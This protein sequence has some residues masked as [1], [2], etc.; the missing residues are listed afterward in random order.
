MLARDQRHN[1]TGP[2]RHGKEEDGAARLG[3][4]AGGV[5]DAVLIAANLNTASGGKRG[6]PLNKTHRLPEGPPPLNSILE[7]ARPEAHIA[8]RA[9]VGKWVSALSMIRNSRNRFSEGHAAIRSGKT[10]IRGNSSRSSSLLAI[11]PVLP[12]RL[13]R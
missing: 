8:L 12:L 13:W 5:A 2:K 3:S 9:D 11:R 1:L 4:G 6:G 10:T 7:T